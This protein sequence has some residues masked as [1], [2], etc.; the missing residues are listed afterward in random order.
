MAEKYTLE[1]IREV[2]PQHYRTSRKRCQELFW[3]TLDRIDK[4]VSAF[5]CLMRDEMFDKAAEGY[6]GWDNDENKQDIANELSA[7]IVKGNYVGAANFCMMLHGFEVIA[8]AMAAERSQ[9]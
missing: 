3:E 6:S 7:H 5:A 8:A 9:E 4:T 2:I 1:E